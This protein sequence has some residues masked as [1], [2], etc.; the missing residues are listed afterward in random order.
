MYMLLCYFVY[1][2]AYLTL[3]DVSCLRY[4][5]FIIRIDK[6]LKNAFIFVDKSGKC[7]ELSEI[8][9]AIEMIAPIMREIFNDTSEYINLRW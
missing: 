7:Q 2:Y 3:S 1:L 4:V 6:F 5:K 9:Y 8:E